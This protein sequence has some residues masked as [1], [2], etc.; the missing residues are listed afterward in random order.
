MWIISRIKSYLARVFAAQRFKRLFDRLAKGETRLTTN[1]LLRWGVFFGSMIFLVVYIDLRMSYYIESN[2]KILRSIESSSLSNIELYHTLMENMYAVGSLGGANIRSYAIPEEIYFKLEDSS[3]ISYIIFMHKLILQGLSI[4]SFGII[5]QVISLIRFIILSNRFNIPTGL[6]MVIIS[7]S[8][9]Y[10]YY[11]DLVYRM[12]WLADQTLRLTDGSLPYI[13]RLTNDARKIETT[14]MK[15]KRTL[16]TP[17]QQLLVTYLDNTVHEIN[18]QGDRLT[19]YYGLKFYHDPFS[20]VVRALFSLMNWTERTDN[21]YGRFIYFL[22]GRFYSQMYSSY[23]YITEKF[24]IPLIKNVLQQG[25]NNRYYIAHI[26][27]VRKGK[28]WMPYLIRWHWTLLIVMGPII[29]MYLHFIVN[30]GRYIRGVLK[31]N[32]DAASRKLMLFKM[33]DQHRGSANSTLIERDIQLEI[34]MA[35]YKL[36]VAYNCQY[37]LVI[38]LISIYVF[39]ALHAVCGQYFF[40]P[41]FAQQIEMH[42]GYRRQN[43]SVYSGGH[44]SWQDLDDRRQIWHGVLGRGK[45]NVPLILTIFDFI[46]NLLTKFFRFFKR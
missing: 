40:I 20:L 7:Y 10:V 4:E 6:V 2:L 21:I 24:A 34:N 14:Y 30:G 22:I 3:Q 37:V 12:K 11:L 39:A 15:N 33:F 43:L 27:L 18:T 42:A 5:L 41:V 46:K 26:Y 8:A 31:P 45:D 28:D 36:D 17:L 19:R 1:D 9:S 13:V 44:T 16:Y 32:Y 23:F 35:Q 25:Y 38:A 29:M